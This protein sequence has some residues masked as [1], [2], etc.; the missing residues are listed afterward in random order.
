VRYFI[1]QLHKRLYLVYFI[2]LV[3][4]GI[5]AGSIIMF[6]N[7]FDLSSVSMP[8]FIKI[9]IITLLSWI[10][11]HFIKKITSALDPTSVDKIK[12]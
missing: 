11:V 4:L 10:P 12:F 5:Y 1:K 6:H 9:L 7:Y 3:S 8:F 2:L